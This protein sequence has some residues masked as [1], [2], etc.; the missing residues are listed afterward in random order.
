MNS[1]AGLADIDSAKTSH[2]QPR[3]TLLTTLTSP[4]GRKVRMAAEILGLSSYVVVSHADTTDPQDRLRIHNPMGKIPCLV[5]ADG[6]AYYDSS[7]IVEYL[8]ELA[9]TERLLPHRGSERIAM[10]RDARLADGIIDAGALV[11]YEERYHNP[12]TRSPYWTAYQKDKIRRSLSAFEKQLP[13]PERS[14]IVSISLSCA[15]GFLDKR[16]ILEWRK[17]HL[18]L[19]AWLE[20]FAANEASFDMTR[21][22]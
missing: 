15:L 9:G 18:R 12:V 11:I 4:F 5:A 7:V 6:N 8:Q 16:Q 2:I 17:T 10:L 20:A 3:L 13:D 21:A 14:D 1:A 22:R 19:V